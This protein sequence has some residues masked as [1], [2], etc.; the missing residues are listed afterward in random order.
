MLYC[1]YSLFDF[2]IG[3]TAQK[4]MLFVCLRGMTPEQVPME[5]QRRGSWIESFGCDGLCRSATEKCRDFGLQLGIELAVQHFESESGL[6]DLTQSTDRIFRFNLVI[7][8]TIGKLTKQVQIDG[9][10][11]IGQCG[12]FLSNLSKDVV[13]VEF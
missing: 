12:G 7:A 11:D 2:G 3:A 8:D 13:S 4:V 5:T 6:K 9:R 10:M 1:I